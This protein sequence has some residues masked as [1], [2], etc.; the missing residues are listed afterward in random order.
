MLRR[1]V[2]T[3][4][5]FNDLYQERFPVGAALLTWLLLFS[6]PNLFMASKKIL[7]V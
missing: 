7:H 6:D 5:W 3:N 1:P 2:G 4:R